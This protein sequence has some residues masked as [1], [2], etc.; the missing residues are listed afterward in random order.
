MCRTDVPGSCLPVPLHVLGHQYAHQTL[1]L[2]CVHLSGVARLPCQHTCRLSLLV[3]HFTRIKRALTCSWYCTSHLTSLCMAANPVATPAQLDLHG[4][5]H[6]LICQH[7]VLGNT[8]ARSASSAAVYAGPCA[9]TRMDRRR[10]WSIHRR[11]TS[12]AS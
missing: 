7:A 4:A 10:Q 8:P 3:E 2:G 11:I 9:W 5:L 6:R 12:S 1:R